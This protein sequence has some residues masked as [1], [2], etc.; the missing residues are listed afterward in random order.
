MDVNTGH[1]VR[2]SYILLLL[3]SHFTQVVAAIPSSEGGYQPTP[4]CKLSSLFHPVKNVLC[5]RLTHT[6]TQRGLNRTQQMLQIIEDGKEK[7]TSRAD[8]I[9]HRL[10]MPERKK[11]LIKDF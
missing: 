1:V 5:A 3:D 4:H 8:E 9:R 10:Q 7:F 2:A 11:K 6:H